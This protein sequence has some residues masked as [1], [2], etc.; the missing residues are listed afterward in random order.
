MLMDPLSRKQH[1]DHRFNSLSTIKGSNKVQGND[2]DR[3]WSL[4]LDDTEHHSAIY[5]AK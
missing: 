2:I 4:S 5:W 1:S 3:L